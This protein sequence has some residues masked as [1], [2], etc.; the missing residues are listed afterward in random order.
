M[1]H[2]FASAGVAGFAFQQ[3]MDGADTTLTSANTW[4]TVVSQ[5]V[6]AGK[7]FVTGVLFVATENSSAS[8]VT[9]RVK[10]GST[11]IQETFDVLPAFA[12]G[13]ATDMTISV[14]VTVPVGGD[15]ITIEIASTA[16]GHQVQDDA[17]Y[18]SASNQTGCR[19]SLFKVL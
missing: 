12:D 16:G 11:V 5:A 8:Y 7:Y 4:Y 2:S 9:L 1:A 18:N 17:P 19:F 15:T 6:D 13:G 3:Y 10:V 14:C